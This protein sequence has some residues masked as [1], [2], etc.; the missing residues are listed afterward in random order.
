M[1]KLN[2]FLLGASLMF[3][4]TVG[5][6][7]CTS[8]SDPANNVND[9]DPVVGPAS[10]AVNAKLAISIAAGNENASTRQDAPA[11]QYPGAGITNGSNFRGMEDIHV[12]AFTPSTVATP[13]FD[14]ANSLALNAI[15]AT[16]I[17]NDAGNAPS[18]R[19]YELTLPVT[20]DNMLFYA[21]AA[22]NSDSEAYGK[23][24]YTLGTETSTVFSLQP[25]VNG[26]GSQFDTY[27]AQLETTLKTIMCTTVNY[28]AGPTVL[29]WPDLMG[30]DMSVATNAPYALLRDAFIAITNT[31]ET[32]RLGSAN[33]VTKMINDLYNNILYNLA[34]NP[35][36]AAAAEA[37]PSRNVY[38]LANAIM[39]AICA[40]DADSG[41]FQFSSANGSNAYPYDL[42]LREETLRTFPN[43]ADGVNLPEGVAQY[44]C[45]LDATTHV[46]TFSYVKV[47]GMGNLTTLGVAAAKVMYP[48]ELMYWCYS[49]LYVTDTE[50][51][52]A[53]FQK[54]TTD[55]DNATV[56]TTAG[57]AKGAVAASTKGVAMVNNV[58]YGTALLKSQVGF[59]ADVLSGTQMQDNQYALTGT[60]NQTWTAN[61]SMLTLTGIIVGGQSKDMG[62]NYISKTSDYSYYVYDNAIADGT[63]SISNTAYAATPNYTMVWDSYVNGTTQMD[64]PVALEFTNNFGDFYG[65]DSQIRMGQKFYLMANLQIA[66]NTNDGIIF[67]SGDYRFGASGTNRIFIQ[68]FM[69]TAVFRIGATSLQKAYATLPSLENSMLYGVSVDLGWS[70]GMA[71]DYEL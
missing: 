2:K 60:A 66:D 49:P 10:T 43:V 37:S 26:Y 41:L 22:G 27:A 50:V 44:T 20:A 12:L 17:G 11:A 65:K 59:S 25:R 23:V 29:A 57:W 16:Q 55:W 13:S 3:L 32:L 45:T 15:P 67:P 6:T 63:I 64:V 52:P 70:Q 7:S 61:S 42:I 28:G 4:G 9:P 5:M 35:A 36:Y 18:S 38:E 1:K 58:N 39:D 47:N 34:T 51:T 19:I 46:P 30:I 33:G 69:T 21:K 40:R 54:T 48:A 71:F 8:D 68:D 62:W 53:S 56:W 24:A 14:L 31:G